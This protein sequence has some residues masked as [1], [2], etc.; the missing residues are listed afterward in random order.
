MFTRPGIDISLADLAVQHGD[1]GATP[2]LSTLR[3]NM[4][5]ALLMPDDPTIAAISSGIIEVPSV[6]DLNCVIDGGRIHHSQLSR[7]KFLGQLS[8]IIFADSILD[9]AE[10][11][12]RIY[13]DGHM[14]R[15]ALTFA[16]LMSRTDLGHLNGHT[17]RKGV[18]IWPDGEDIQ[19]T[20][21]PGYRWF[22]HSV[23]LSAL[24]RGM[25]ALGIDPDR[26]ASLS[27]G[28]T[29]QVPVRESLECLLWSIHQRSTSPY[30]VANSAILEETLMLQFLDCLF[31]DT[32]MSGRPRITGAHLKR[33]ED[34][35]NQ[36]VDRPVTATEL[37]E[38]VRCSRRQLE[39]AFR[40]NY[41]NGPIAVHRRIRLS[42][43]HRILRSQNAES[44]TRAAA[45]CGFSH[46]GRFSADYRNL[47]GELPSQTGRRPAG[48]VVNA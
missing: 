38:V 27:V 18:W 24:T 25:E 34:Y 4:I 22:T 36:V 39:Y 16:Y 6:D 5:G 12:Q 46:L 42:R 40:D 29:S 41:G 32:N 48:I 3:K 33:A 31:T 11:S 14:P 2:L 10:Y 45:A 13:G 30:V 26:L 37:C 19:G 15:Q 7:G 20:I 23:Q 9:S 43:A 17:L 35:L 47:F 8:R 21:P 44:V 28:P 1:V